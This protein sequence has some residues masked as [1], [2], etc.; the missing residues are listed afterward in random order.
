VP[1]QVCHRHH[2]GL[3]IAQQPRGKGMPEHVRGYVY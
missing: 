2:V 3:C 1:H